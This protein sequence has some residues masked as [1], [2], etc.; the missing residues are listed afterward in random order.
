MTQV[1]PATIPVLDIKPRPKFIHVTE[2]GN[3]REMP[4]SFI[5]IASPKP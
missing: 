1:T 5:S 3:T 4:I 2:T